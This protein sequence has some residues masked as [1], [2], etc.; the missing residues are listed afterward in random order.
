MEVETEILSVDVFSSMLILFTYASLMEYTT[1]K[2]ISHNNII[3]IN[4]IEQRWNHTARSSIVLFSSE[5]LIWFLTFFRLEIL[6]VRCSVINYIGSN[7]HHPTDIYNYPSF[8]NQR[9]DAVQA[10]RIFISEQHK[11]S[12]KSY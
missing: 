7:H 8:R 2:D 4:K 11:N 3:L 5:F 9:P 6:P 1:R 12:P 10:G